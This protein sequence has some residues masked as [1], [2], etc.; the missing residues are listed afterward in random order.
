MEC[1]PQ[2]ADCAKDI[3]KK[4]SSVVTVGLNAATSG[5]FGEISKASKKVQQGVKCGQQLFSAVNKVMGY[6]NEVENGGKTDT[7]KD[8]LMFLLSKSQFATQDLPVAVS[9]CLGMP[10]PTNL[11]KADKVVNIVKSILEKVLNSKEK[12]EDVLSIILI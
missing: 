1:F 2:N 4:A 8:Q 9:T 12:G 7:T 10:V 3:I 11:D 5:V 6:I